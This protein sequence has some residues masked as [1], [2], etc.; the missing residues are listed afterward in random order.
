MVKQLA[1]QCT[2]GG[3]SIID[4]RLVLSHIVLILEKNNAISEII[5][6]KL[7]RKYVLL[8]SVVHIIK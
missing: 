3:S 4:N 6:L 1:I 7:V 5:T 2:S 8:R